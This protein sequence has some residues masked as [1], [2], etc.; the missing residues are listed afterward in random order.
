M[1]SIV[2]EGY[3]VTIARNLQDVNHHNGYK[4]LKYKFDLL[5]VKEY[6]A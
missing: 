6:E 3:Q 2:H 4:F 1:F 5:K